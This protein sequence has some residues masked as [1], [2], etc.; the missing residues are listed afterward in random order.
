MSVEESAAGNARKEKKIRWIMCPN[1]IW[2]IAFTLNQS[3]TFIST[4][5][6]IHCFCFL[7]CILLIPGTDAPLFFS[8]V[9]TSSL[10]FYSLVQV[11][12]GQSIK[13][14]QERDPVGRERDTVVGSKEVENSSPSHCFGFPA[15]LFWYLKVYHTKA[16]KQRYILSNDNNWEKTRSQD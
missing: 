10:S 14:S 8:R 7:F 11:F 6:L 2:I 1:S 13:H 5:T 12:G 3:L 16:R 4:H 15:G 9:L